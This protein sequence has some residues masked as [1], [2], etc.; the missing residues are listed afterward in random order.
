MESLERLIEFKPIEMA[1][2]IAPRAALFMAAEN[3]EL[4]PAEGV[5]AMYQRAGEPKAYE[6]LPGITHYEIYEEPHVSR[7][8]ALT[9]EWIRAH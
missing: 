4:T 7:L 5:E 2:R 8:I 1:A 9:D 3:D 6:R